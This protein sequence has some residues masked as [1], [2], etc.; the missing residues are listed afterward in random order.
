MKYVSS[1]IVVEDVARARRLYEGILGQKVS[2]DFGENVG[3]EAGFAIHKKAHFESLIDGRPV[4]SGS[5]WGEL[6]FEEDD[7]V[8]VERELL[9][10]GYE[11]VHGIREQPWKQRVMRFYDADRN[12]VEIGESL[13]FLVHRLTESGNSLEEVSKLTGIPVEGVKVFLE[14]YKP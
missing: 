4:A 13:E 1:L 10:Q 7:L 14:R 6:Y 3:F 12:I 2:A 5:N 11:F 9:A 8:P